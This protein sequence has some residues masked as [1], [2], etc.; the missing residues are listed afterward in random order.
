MQ[1]IGIHKCMSYTSMVSHWCVRISAMKSKPLRVSTY[2]PPLWRC[3]PVASRLTASMN[4]SLPS[5]LRNSSTGFWIYPSFKST[6][7]SI[8]FLWFA[9]STCWAIL[10]TAFSRSFLFTW[11]S[12]VELIPASDIKPIMNSEQSEVQYRKINACK[13]YSLKIHDWDSRLL[14]SSIVNHVQGGE[15]G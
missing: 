6:I 11:F 15:E 8:W 13:S 9:A 2:L 3:I 12:F 14:M 1:M 4:S 10:A 7:F 5:I